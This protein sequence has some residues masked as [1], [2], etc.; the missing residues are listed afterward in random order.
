[1]WWP[2]IGYKYH[3]K[4]RNEIGITSKTEAYIQ[5]LVLK[6]RAF[7]LNEDEVFK[8]GYNEA[9]ALVSK[10]LQTSEEEKPAD[11]QKWKFTIF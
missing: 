10:I 5:S 6:K 3:K 2:N 11:I 4:H 7:P 9:D 1:M 8:D